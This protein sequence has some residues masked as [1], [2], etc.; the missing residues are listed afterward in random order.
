MWTLWFPTHRGNSRFSWAQTSYLSKQIFQ[1]TG[2][3]ERGCIWDFFFLI[4]IFLLL[5]RMS[6]YRLLIII[7]PMPVGEIEP[8]RQENKCQFWERGPRNT[9]ERCPD[10]THSAWC[11]RLNLPEKQADR[12]TFQLRNTSLVIKFLFTLTNTLWRAS[13][14]NLSMTQED[15]VT[16]H[17]IFLNRKI[18]LTRTRSWPS[19]SLHL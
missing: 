7:G 8:G 11:W 10:C 9:W 12:P 19:H 16:F 17:Y 6:P 2:I 15:K 5:W 14:Q 18:Q 1:R 13:C 3:K 4:A